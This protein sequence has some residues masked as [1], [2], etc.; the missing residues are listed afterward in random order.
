MIS[1]KVMTKYRKSKVTLA[2]LKI[3]SLA[4]HFGVGINFITFFLTKNNVFSLRF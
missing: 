4:I 3:N 2:D 1:H